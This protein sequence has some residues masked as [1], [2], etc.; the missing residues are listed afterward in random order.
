[1]PAEFIDDKAS[2]SFTATLDK[3]IIRTPKIA[4]SMLTAGAN[5]LADEVR[6]RL[7]SMFAGGWYQLPGAFGVTP[8]QMRKDGTYNKK[9]GF[10]GYQLNERRENGREYAYKNRKAFQLIANIIENGAVYPKR[11]GFTLKAR[12]FFGPALKANKARIESAMES[13]AEYEFE[14]IEKGI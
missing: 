14:K 13:A 11:K 6:R 7:A 12:P 5:V 10:G 1:M 2:A 3:T 9:V 4:D 8:T